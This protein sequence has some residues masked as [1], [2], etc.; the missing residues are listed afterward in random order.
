MLSKK[1]ALKVF[2]LVLC[3]AVVVS[4]GAAGCGKKKVD[5]SKSVY[6]IG[7]VLSLSGPASPLG[8]PEENSLKMLE[9]QLNAGEGVDGHKVQFVIEDD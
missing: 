2:A 1:G 4:L 6:K 5:T 8:L 7:A 9:E 3:A